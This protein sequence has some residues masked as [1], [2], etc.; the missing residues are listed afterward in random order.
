M[1]FVEFAGEL[2]RPAGYVPFDGELDAPAPAED[3]TRPAGALRR[4][5]PAGPKERAGSVLDDAY[6]PEPEFDAA[7]AQRLS[8]RDYAV[9]T[10]IPGTPEKPQQ[11]LEQGPAPKVIS[12][13]TSRGQAV[14]DSGIPGARIAGQVA[15]GIGSGIGGVAR[16][17]GDVLGVDALSRAGEATAA[18]AGEFERGIGE[19]GAVAGFGP[20]SPV[21]YLGRMAE[22]AASSLGQSAILAAFGPGAVIPAMAVLSAG[23]EYDK[24]RIAGLD[25]AAA[26]AGAIPKGAFEAIGEKF[27]GLDKVAGAMGTLLQRGASD[28]AKRT[29]ADVLVR[30]GIREIPGEVITYLGQTGVDLLPGIGL[31]PDLTMSQFIDG[32]RDTVVQSAMM[33]GAIGGGGVVARRSTPE[34]LPSARQMAVDRGFLRQPTAAESIADIGAAG[35]VDEAIAAATR[36]VTAPAELPPEMAG[37]VQQILSATTAVDNIAQILGVPDAATSTESTTDGSTGRTGALAERAGDAVAPEPVASLGTAGSAEPGAGR[38]VPQPDAGAAAAGDGVLPAPP[39]DSGLD[40]VAAPAA[41]DLATADPGALLLA[42]QDPTSPFQRIAAAELRRRETDAAYAQRDQQQDAEREAIRMEARDQQVS[43][44]TAAS[45][46]AEVEAPTAMQLAME[47]ARTKAGPAAAPVPASAPVAAPRAPSTR[48]EPASTW[49]GRRGDGYLTSGDA[50][51]ALRTRQKV[52]PELDWRIEQ[53]AGGKF[54]LAGYARAGVAQPAAGGQNEAL[55][56]RPAASQA[57]QPAP[58]LTAGGTQSQTAPELTAAP[59]VQAL[60]PADPTVD[61]SGGPGQQATVDPRLIPRSR[62]NVQNAP[63]PAAQQAA[64]AEARAAAPQA[65]TAGAARPANADTG[66]AAPATPGLVKDQRL[67]PVSQRDQPAVPLQ[68]DTEAKPVRKADEFVPAPAGGEDFGEIT[69]DMGRTMRRQAGRIRLQQG[70]EL[71]GLRHIEARHGDQIRKLGFPDVQSFVADALG[72]I[73]AVWQPNATS[74]LVVVQAR[75]KGRAVFIELRAGKDAEGDFYTVRSAFPTGQGYAERKKGWRQVWGAGV[76]DP[77]DGSGKPSSFAAPANEAG[78][79]ATM[80]SSQTAEP[81]VPA[82]QKARDPRLTPVSK[83]AKVKPQDAAEVIPRKDAEDIVGEFKAAGMQRITLVETDAD[84]PPASQKRIKSEGLKGVRGVYEPAEDMVYLVRENLRGVTEATFTIFHEAFHRGLRKTIPAVGPVLDQIYLSNPS[85]RDAAISYAKR[86]EIGK[87][88]TGVSKK[89]RRILIRREATEEVL[90]NMAGRNDRSLDDLRGWRRLVQVIRDFLDRLTRAAGVKMEWTDEMVRDLVAGARNAGMR[91][92]L[93]TEQAQQVEQPMFSR[94]PEPKQPSPWRDSLGRFQFAPGQMLYDWLGD[95]ASP[96]LVK[97]GMK[98]ASPE[99]RRQLR[100]MKL[101][102]EKAKEIAVAVAKEAANLSDAEREMVSDLVEQE[103]QAGT[104]PPAHA[105]KLAKVINTT[106]EAQTDELVRLGML[107]KDAADMWRGRYLPRYYK[108]KLSKVVG[109]VWADALKNLSRRPTAMQGIKGK[110]LKGRGLYETIKPHE[111]PDWQALGWEVRDPTFDPKTSKDVQIWRDFTRAEREKMGEIRDSGFRF[112]MGYMQTQR[113]IALGRMYDNMANDPDSS[114][115][116]EKPGYVQVPSTKVQGTGAMRYGN[117]AGRWVP[118]ET[119][120]HLSQMEEAQSD[121]WTLY[122]QAMG[123]WKESKTVLNPVSHVN[124]ILSNVT[125]AHLGGVSYGRADKYLAA[126]KDFAMKSPKIAEAKEAGLFLGTLSD[127]ELMNTLPKTLQVLARQQETA[128]GK[129]GRTTMNLLSFFLRKPMGW[130][131]QAED[132]FFRYLLYREARNNGLEPNDAV[133]YAQK[134]IFTYDDL[135]KGARNVRDFALPFFSYTY[136][137]VPAL[138]HTAL[139]HPER[140]VA[141]AAVMWAINAAA[142]A[143]AAGDDDDS[144]ET[145]LRRYVTEPEFRKKAREKEELEREFLPPWMKGMTAFATPKTIRLGMDEVTKLPLFID[146]SR[147]IPG[148]DLFDVSPNAGGLPLPQPVTPSHPLFSTAV[149][150]L[151]NKDLFRGKELIDSNDTRWEAAEKRAAW[152]WDQFTPAIAVN[153]YHWE[154]GMNALAQAVGGELTYIPDFLGG[155]ATGVGRDGLPVQPKLAAAQTFGIKVR[156]LDLDTS[157]S[158]QEN[159]KRK[160]IRDID[161]EIASLRRL[162]SKGAISASTL[163][164]KRDAALEKKDRLREGLT[165]DG[166][167]RE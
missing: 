146:V 115:R 161:A 28:Q 62:R 100:Q 165:V 98:A 64:A 153:N 61:T 93:Q 118:Q 123:V 69:P 36:A 20:K 132:T 83:R 105:V 94:A 53:T 125:M 134:F 110:H 12:A 59:S 137:A 162:Y 70:N 7:E 96:M 22:G 119:M 84:L 130:A 85:V 9:R 79:R 113:D 16:A 42:A 57:A 95:K 13:A 33:G 163:D 154:R 6:M 43:Q 35:S 45:K 24:A 152:L 10:P 121:A 150:M 122:R 111:L 164:K 46:A 1:P 4:T 89:E 27:S 127:A 86:H 37:D 114:S 72:K 135:P 145:S 133:D 99:L 102:V 26:L 117:L 54:R 56:E 50:G 139:T 49:Y 103:V 52:A 23:Q 71:F 124:N 14:A 140:A 87:G 17:A 32:L 141:P 8:R 147:I 19:S 131:Y 39:A 156:P 109:D 73:E 136:K 55:R 158:I 40:A 65:R 91:A 25:P 144:W 92:D 51:L 63:A 15:A 41:P 120:S 67:V 77:A 129:V 66:A 78:R 108:S 107:S 166:D 157:E 34:P 138:L 80:E 58:S 151:A 104:I 112:V 75:E 149:A 82:G 155:D 97:L 81:I 88:L 76:P 116:L 2:D 30:S 44:A 128:T 159:Q 142:Y 5:I 11:S 160:M 21:P 101:D 47:R 126:M 18:G 31:N 29:A 106:M 90:A 148:G 74:Q 38:S 3:L 60:A 167:K 143:I 68:R 48:T